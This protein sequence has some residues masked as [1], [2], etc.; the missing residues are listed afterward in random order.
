[1]PTIATIERQA[2][3]AL[4]VAIVVSMCPYR[5]NYDER[6]SYAS[7]SCR[8]LFREIVFLIVWMDLPFL[9]QLLGLFGTALAPAGL[10]TLSTQLAILQD[11]AYSIK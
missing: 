10:L 2:S 4:R 8:F 11:H 9:E 6:R 3:R 7:F 1:V 5:R